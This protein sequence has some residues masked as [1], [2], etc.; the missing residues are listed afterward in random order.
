[1]ILIDLC[2]VAF[3]WYLWYQILTHVFNGKVE[4]K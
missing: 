3:G 2:F 1:M 4:P